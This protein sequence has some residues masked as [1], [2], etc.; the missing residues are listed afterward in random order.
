MRNTTSAGISVSPC[1]NVSQAAE[2]CILNTV[3]MSLTANSGNCFVTDQ[4]VSPKLVPHFRGNQVRRWTKQ[5]FRSLPWWRCK[6]INPSQSNF[7]HG[8]SKSSSEFYFFL[9]ER[10]WVITRSL[11][12]RNVGGISI[13]WHFKFEFLRSVQAHAKFYFYCPDS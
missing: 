4:V 9:W 7:L 6:K 2:V 12:M 3:A 1:N 11:L 8:L 10:I 13:H 5:K